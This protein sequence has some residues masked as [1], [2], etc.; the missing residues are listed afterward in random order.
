[1]KIVAVDFETANEQRR[2][3]CSVGFAFVENG[4]VV[5]V[6]ERLIRPPEMRFSRFNISIHGIRPEDVEDAPQF[7]QV[8]EEFRDDCAGALMLAHNAAFDMSVW[9]AA[10]DHY[11]LAYPAFDYLCTVQMARRVWQDLPS[12]KLNALGRHLCIAFN[13]HNAAEDASVCAQVALA[14]ATD[15]GAADIAAIPALIGLTP[16]RLYAGGYRPARAP[17][18]VS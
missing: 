12:Y 2:S 10:L 4:A 9:R 1:M 8:M 17:S 15:L 5:R 11:G 13:H 3:A 16:G 6:E 18:P 7:P 14:L